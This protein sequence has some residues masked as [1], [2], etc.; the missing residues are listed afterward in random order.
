LLN[1]F[2]QKDVVPSG[3]RYLKRRLRSLLP[4]IVH[5]FTVA[6]AVAVVLVAILA[7][8]V[9]P[10]MGTHASKMAAARANN[11]AA[12][13]LAGRRA[14]VFGGTQGIGKALALRLAK[15]GAGVTIVGRNEKAGSEVIEALKEAGPSG[16]HTFIKADLSLMRNAH[17]AAEELIT[18]S[19][20]LD[21]VVFCQTKATIQGRTPTSEGID[22]KLALNFYSRAYLT[23]LLTPVMERSADQHGADV[24]FLSVLSAGVHGVYSN[25]RTDPY[26][27][28]SFS[29]KNAADAAGFYNDL[30]LDREATQHPKVTFA[31]AAPGF[32]DSNW[33]AEMPVALKATIRCIQA[34]PLAKSADDCAELLVQGLIADRHRGGLR[35]LNEHGDEARKTPEHTA[36]A[37]EHVSSA[38]HKLLDP[39]FTPLAL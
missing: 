24:R 22:E 17:A 10:P 2:L 25:Y 1:V 32:V 37:V 20:R 38:T 12:G 27:E 3:R 13:S 18:A 34:T 36:E 30:F 39:L 11:A 14:V 6:A 9:L 23:W 16:A 35:L 26:L 5:S 7:A 29:L 28:T 33:G 21:Y 15:G 31:H 19:P 8:F 4:T